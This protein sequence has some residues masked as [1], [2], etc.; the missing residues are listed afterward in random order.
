VAI[1]HVSN[2]QVVALVE[3]VALGNKNKQNVLNSFVRKA[4]EPRG[5][6]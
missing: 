6:R 4:R 5:G 2:H 1:R 3:I